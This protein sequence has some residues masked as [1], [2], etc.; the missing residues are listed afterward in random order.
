LSTFLI[1]IGIFISAL[2]MCCCAN[3]EQ[4]MW[5]IFHWIR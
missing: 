3:S 5:N 2:C 1:T 4:V